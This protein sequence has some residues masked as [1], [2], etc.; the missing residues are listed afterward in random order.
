MNQVVFI[1]KWQSLYCVGREDE[2]MVLFIE[3]IITCSYHCHTTCSQLVKWVI[4]IQR[5]TLLSAAAALLFPK[6]IH[7]LHR[8]F[9][10][11]SNE[12]LIT[13]R[14]ESISAG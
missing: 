4:I 1:R 9:V 8:V 13:H 14:R 5:I 10:S 6:I 7:H 11:F 12:H 3:I 2:D